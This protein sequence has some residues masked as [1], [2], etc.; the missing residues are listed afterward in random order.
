MTLLTTRP[1]WQA[2]AAHQEVLANQRI[3]ALFAEN[4]A[5]AFEFSIPLEEMLFDFSKNLV[6]HETLT[7]LENLSQACGLQEAIA[8]L[9]SGQCVNTT[10]NKPALHTA[11][12]TP[13]TT[14]FEIAGN[15]ISQAIQKTLTQ[16]ENLCHLLD[17]N[18][19]L[20]YSKKPFTDIVNVG[21][22][23][24]EL[25]PRLVIE[26]LKPYHAQEKR[27]HFVA[28]ID[29]APLWDLL[30]RLNPETTLWIISSKSFT[31]QETLLH[32]QTIRHHFASAYESNAHFN[33]H[34][35]AV[36]ANPQAAKNLGF[37][38]ENI[39][40]LWDWVGGRYS[41]WSAIGLSAALALGFENFKAFLKGAHT[42]DEHFKTA[43]VKKNIPIMMGLLGIWYH[44]FFK[45]PTHAI[46]PYCEALKTLPTYLQQLQ[47]ESNGKSTTRAGHPID[48]YT[49]CP[50][51]WGEV[52]A[53]SQHAFHQLFHQ[54]TQLVPCDFII[55]LKSHH[56][57]E[58]H[59]TYLV[60]SCFSQS[61][62]LMQ[63]KSEKEAYENHQR[64]PGNQ[65]SN[66]LLFKQLTPFTLGSLLALYEHKTYVQSVIW[67]INP[68]DQWGIELGK[69][70]VTQILTQLQA[71]KVCTKDSSTT[72]LIE[73]YQ[74][75]LKGNN[76]AL[77]K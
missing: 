34:F 65:P 19:L 25:G 15:D 33:Q 20:G 48:T 17:Q 58:D 62:A 50:I 16:I 9:F 39:Y 64:I 10:E 29:G 56:P 54:G 49:T 47:M 63:G 44:N 43:P 45:A 57:L 36:T 5:R 59:H 2:L 76:N 4:K 37:S 28:N 51:I 69:Q 7:L 42:V 35:I 27:F 71:E 32:L 30:T 66:T 6:T 26:A 46:V 55:P 41:V 73:C 12:R 74:H 22:G 14:P 53:N 75:S 38:P 61:Q 40:E 24:S 23:G 67:D 70:L 77:K 60:A 68:F 18:R 31:T 72:Q 52:G 11:L 8:D 1:A 21:I 3:S 13:T